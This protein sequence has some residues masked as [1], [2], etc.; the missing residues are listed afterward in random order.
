LSCT[1]AGRWRT[2]LRGQCCSLKSVHPELV[3]GFARASTGSARTEGFYQNSIGCAVVPVAAL[4]RCL[5]VCRCA[6]YTADLLLRPWWA[7]DRRAPTLSAALAFGMYGAAASRRSPKSGGQPRSCT[8]QTIGRTQVWCQIF[9]CRRTHT[10]SRADSRRT[11]F[12]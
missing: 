11:E 7:I 10:R 9:P 5:L 8:Y 6:E 2:Q 3:E 1:G 12:S 4:G